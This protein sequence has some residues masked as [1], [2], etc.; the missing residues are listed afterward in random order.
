[1]VTLVDYLVTDAKIGDPDDPFFHHLAEAFDRLADAG[2]ILEVVE[3]DEKESH[4]RFR[5]WRDR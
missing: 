2:M 3:R 1:V 4:I 5:A